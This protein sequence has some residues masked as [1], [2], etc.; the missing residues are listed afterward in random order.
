ML[1]SNRTASRVALT[2]IAYLAVVCAVL[3]FAATASAASVKHC[4]AEG[5]AVALTDARSAPDVTRTMRAGETFV[6]ASGDD[7]YASFSDLHAYPLHGGTARE[8]RCTARHGVD[9]W[10]EWRTA[11]GRVLVTYDGAMF[12]AR[13]SVTVAAWKG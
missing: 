6:P 2:F 11:R 5:R 7:A 13:A 9:I 10:D 4:R 8:Y 1:P 3:T 12:T